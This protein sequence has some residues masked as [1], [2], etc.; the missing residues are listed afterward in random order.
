MNGLC[1]GCMASN[2]AWCCLVKRRISHITSLNYPAISSSSRTCRE[3]MEDRW[4]RKMRRVRVA[5]LT[6][7][8]RLCPFPWH[9]GWLHLAFGLKFDLFLSL[10]QWKKKKK[11]TVFRSCSILSIFLASN[12]R[13]CYTVRQHHSLVVV[14]SA[15]SCTQPSILAAA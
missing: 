9:A 5:G 6:R 14:A 13:Y 1:K 3:R 7:Q 11:A 4:G 10:T 8:T 15:C 2:T 12:R